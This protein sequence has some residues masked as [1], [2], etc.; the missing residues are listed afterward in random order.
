MANNRIEKIKEV[1]LLDDVLQGSKKGGWSPVIQSINT[2]DSSF[3]LETSDVGKYLRCNSA[4]T[5]TVTITTL[6]YLDGSCIAFEQAGAGTVTLAAGTGVTLNGDLS[7]SAQYGVIQIIKVGL[8]E[9]TVIG[10]TTV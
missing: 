10:G 3:T 7:T 4:S 6:A 8:N 9:W 1:R 2:K 5:I